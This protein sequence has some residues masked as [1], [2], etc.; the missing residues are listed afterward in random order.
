MPVGPDVSEPVAV[1]TFHALE[2]GVDNLTLTNVDVVDERA[3]T[4]ISCSGTTPNPQCVG[5]TRRQEHAIADDADAYTYRHGD[6]HTERYADQHSHPRARSR[7]RH[8]GTSGRRP[9]VAL[10]AAVRRHRGR[11]CGRGGRSRG[12]ELVRQEA[13]AGGLGCL[14]KVQRLPAPVIRQTERP[15]FTGLSSFDFGEP[16]GT[17]TRNLLIKS[18]LLY[19]LS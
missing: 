12:G 10:V 4:Y 15:V 8:C 11:R 16:P 1:V 19:Q 18:Q 6:Q 2:S 14:C 3:V 7:R 9:T 13:L 5:A 17:R